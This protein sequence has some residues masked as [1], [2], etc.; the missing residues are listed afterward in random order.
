MS[1]LD[2]LKM[3]LGE[4]LSARLDEV[5]G[6]MR[7]EEMVAQWCALLMAARHA[8]RNIDR[9]PI[10]FQRWI[11]D[12]VNDYMNSEPVKGIEMPEGLKN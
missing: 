12:Y 3:I 9:M 4:L 1:R 6:D 7:S 8:Q 11:D 2:E 10:S 5:S